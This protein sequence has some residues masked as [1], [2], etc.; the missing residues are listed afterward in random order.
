MALAVAGERLKDF[1]QI[2]TATH[3]QEALDI[4][5]REL[6]DVIL[7]DVT[8]PDMNGFAVIE[9][10]KEDER[11]ADI[12]VIFWSG[13]LLRPEDKIRGLNLGAFDYLLKPADRGEL[14]ARVQVGLR[15]KQVER[16]MLDGVNLAF[17]TFRHE[18]NAPVQALM[19][20]LD[21]M[22]LRKDRLDEPHRAQLGRMREELRK[23]S[24][25][26]RNSHEIQ[27][28]QKKTTAEGEVLQLNTSA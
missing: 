7:L 19:T 8:L 24:T 25:V 27:Q 17:R 20:S 5:T 26:I 9:K 3:G 6:P 18:L 13:T 16:A 11:L 10:L 28:I 21:L 23:I 2:L 1:A 15:L 14:I 12:Y 4:A 22:E